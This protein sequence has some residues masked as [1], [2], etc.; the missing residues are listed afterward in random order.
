M[1]GQRDRAD[2]AAPG[3]GDRRR[4]RGTARRAASRCSPGASPT[5]G[6]DPVPIMSRVARDPRAVAPRAELI[7]ASPREVLN[8]VQ[9]DAIGCHII[10]MTH[11]LSRSSTCSARTSTQFSLETV[12]M[13]RPRRASSAGFTPLSARCERALDHR[14]RRVHRQHARRPAAAPTASRSSS[15]TTSRPGGGSSSQ[16]R[17]RAGRRRRSCEGDV[18]DGDAAARAR[19][20]GCDTVFHLAANADVRFGLDAPA[21]RPRA[22]HDRHL[23]RARG[24]ARR[25]RHADRVLVHRLGLRRARGLP[26]ARGRARSRCRRRSTAPRSSRARG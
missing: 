22:E 9:A 23:R 18:L 24:D 15:T 20:E 16:A 2:D 21:P 25:R 19:C 12:Q 3:R 11:D 4:P 5:P 8:I 6:V 13:F 1:Q 10:T 14:R 7:W 26:D 17:S